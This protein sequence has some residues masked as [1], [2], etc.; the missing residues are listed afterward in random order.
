MDKND[1]LHAIEAPPPPR[2]RELDPL[3]VVSSE[4]S[5]DDFIV[6]DGHE[7]EPDIEWVDERSH[8]QPARKRGSVDT[9]RRS[10]RTKL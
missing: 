1:E 6:P 7:S 4:D 5:M 8:R 3:F 9:R 2:E 10:K